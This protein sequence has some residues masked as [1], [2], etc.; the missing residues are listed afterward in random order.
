M[1]VPE[2]IA[3]LARREGVAQVANTTTT[4]VLT[5]GEVG[6]VDEGG[7]VEGLGRGQLGVGQARAV[8]VQ[9]LESPGRAS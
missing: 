2:Q 7:E 8:R 5:D 6:L 3:D 1:G 9:E 4:V